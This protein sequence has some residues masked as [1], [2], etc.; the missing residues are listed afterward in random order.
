MLIGSEKKLKVCCEKLCFLRN[1]NMFNL[2][3]MHINYIIM[4]NPTDTAD[5]IALKH[6]TK[7][8]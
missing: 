4:E 8:W 7:M 5:E 2:E 1:K 3:L 6:N